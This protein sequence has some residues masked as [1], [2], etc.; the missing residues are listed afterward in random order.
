[1]RS[2]SSRNLLSTPLARICESFPSTM[3]RCRLRN[4]VGILY[5]VGFWMMVTMRSSSSDVSSP[6]LETEVS[7]RVRRCGIGG[8]NVPLVEIDVGFLA[9]EVGVAAADTL[10]FGHGVH[11]LLFSIDV[12]VEKTE[13]DGSR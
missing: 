8:G 6:A 13:L 12:G 5:C 3:S 2:K 1:M 9:H 7:G 11:D 10:D 4:H